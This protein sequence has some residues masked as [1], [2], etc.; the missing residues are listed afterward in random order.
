MTVRRLTSLSANPG[1]AWCFVEEVAEAG[2]YA[3]GYR[4]TLANSTLDQQLLELASPAPF[5]IERLKRL[6]APTR[7]FTAAHVGKLFSFGRDQEYQREERQ[8]QS[9]A[10]ELGITE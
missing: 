3:A 1:F 10:D 4:L 7:Y 8:A 6:R 5:A 2:W 9:C